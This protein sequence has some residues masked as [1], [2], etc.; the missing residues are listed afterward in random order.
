MKMICRPFVLTV[1]AVAASQAMAQ[2]PDAGALQR[3]IEKQLPQEMPA[4]PFRLKPPTAAEAPKPAAAQ[5]T[6]ELKG[7]RFTG[8][9][10]VSSEE[11]QANL[12]SWMRRTVTFAQLDEITAQVM[13][14]YRNKGLIAQAIVPPQ[15]ITDG[16]LEIRVIES[17]LSDV[18][19]NPGST[20]ATRFNAEY[21]K[22]FVLSKNALGAIVSPEAIE[23]AVTLI[24]EAGG[25]RAS[26]SLEAGKE[27]GDTNFNLMLE[28]LPLVAGTV[29]AS[30][31]GS[32]ST[33]IAQGTASLGLNNITGYGDAASVYGIKNEGSTYGQVAY[34]LP[35][36]YSGLKL[37]VNASSLNYRNVGAFA[38]S[39]SHGSSRVR[40]VNVSYPLLGDGEYSVR[41]HASL[42]HKDY[43]NLA[44][45]G[46]VSQYQIKN[47]TTGFS[48]NFG[49]QFFGLAGS[50]SWSLSYVSGDLTI[51]DLKQAIQDADS[52]KTNGS[53]RKV[54]YS[55]S[56]L[57]TLIPEQTALNLSISGQWASKNLNS[58]EQFYLGGPS[59]VRAYPVSQAGGAQGVVASLELR[60]S[61]ID[62]LQASA[63]IDSGWVMQHK[64]LY[65]GWQGKSE[66]GNSYR[67]SGVGLGLKW[68]QTRYQVSATI[69]TPWGNNP[70]KDS[71][72]QA[73][74]SD[75]RS[76]NTQG[77]VS[78]SFF[79]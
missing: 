19:I 49:T 57:Q 2:G 28:D 39:E 41:V 16:I 5:T 6:F 25:V 77:W 3:Q 47:V 48:G 54:L 14:Y 21:A 35:L 64:D 78:A 70:L 61:I 76:M 8:N 52:V 74:N 58:G 56:K 33:G 23:R 24:N 37:G 79:F 38:A 4:A 42:D 53:F 11:L 20:E 1:L 59:G 46:I 44:I 9:T 27:L 43:E 15:S 22:G 40:G 63:F 31:Q 50:D 65:T 66:A 12:R 60:Q 75:G 72:G 45:A 69:A 17:K 7:F 62:G 10:L 30:N 34:S 68:I 32:R 55:Y 73:V 18:I 71:R 51:Q 36:G 13:E 67:L 29:Q 26:G